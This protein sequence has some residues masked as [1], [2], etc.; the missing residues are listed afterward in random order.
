MKFKKPKFWDQQRP[1]FLSNFLLP[2]T[3]PLKLNNLIIESHRKI[4]FKKI[5][6][7]CIGNIYIGGTGKTPL[8]I[9]IFDII[10]KFNKK[11]VVAK[12]FYS[13]HID[14]ILLLKKYSRTIFGQSRIQL[15]ETAL[16]KKF[17]IIIFDDGLQEKKINYDLKF[18]C[19][20]SSKWIGNGR[21]L[22][23][24]PLRQDIKILNKLDAVFLKNLKK[25]NNKKIIKLI[26]SINP[27]LQIFN[28][29]IKIVNKNEFDLK[30]KYLAVSGIG[31]PASFSNLLKLN[32]FKITKSI[33][34]PDHHKYD[35][36]E[37]KNLIENSKKLKSLI[38]T[39]E[40]D[41]V[42]IPKRFS[43]FFKYIKIDIEIE[44]HKKLIKYL[45]KELNE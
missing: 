42:K 43:N 40:K 2:F 37:I 5:K 45:K 13:S 26:K 30:N 38:I 25:N 24:G 19:F 31:N 3:L 39:T 11:V 10:N 41:Y 15:I 1:N 4:R 34:F 35:E 21:L 18:I 9:K 44:N 17:K 6:S 12:K 20:D 33:T 7:I 8:A 28:Y 27:N 23:A 29:L 14:E 16:K 32:N 36:I 22:P